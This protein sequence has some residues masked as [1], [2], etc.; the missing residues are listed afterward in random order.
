MVNYNVTFD[1][2]QERIEKEQLILSV[3]KKLKEWSNASEKAC[4][5]FAKYSLNN[6]A[7]TKSG[8][9]MGEYIYFAF[10]GNNF[11]FANNTSSYRGKAKKYNKHITTGEIVINFKTKKQFKE[12]INEFYK[13]VIQNPTANY[14]DWSKYIDL[15]QSKIKEKYIINAIKQHQ[16]A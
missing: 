11:A 7:T 4:N 3:A 9:S 8:Y 12:C 6:L 15:E 16:V 10:K 14:F 13:F 2:I 1:E 5:I